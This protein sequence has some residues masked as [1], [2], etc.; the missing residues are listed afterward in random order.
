MA[1]AP[2]LDIVQ[3]LAALE[4]KVTALETARAAIKSSQVMALTS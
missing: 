1:A 3:R 4:A 2:P